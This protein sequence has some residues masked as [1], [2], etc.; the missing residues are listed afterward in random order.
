MKSSKF[1]GEQEIYEPALKLM[2]MV[3]TPLPESSTLLEVSQDIE[4]S[5]L[6]V[7][8]FSSCRRRDEEIVKKA[9]QKIAYKTKDFN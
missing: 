2:G 7:K 6:K 5:I 4:K 3:E 9:P 8:T 1:Q